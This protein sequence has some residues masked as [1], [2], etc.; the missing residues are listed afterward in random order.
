MAAAFALIKYVETIQN[1]AFASNSMRIRF[2]PVEECCLIG[3]FMLKLPL[4]SLIC[5]IV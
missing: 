5:I 4:L 1:I 3:V 2:E